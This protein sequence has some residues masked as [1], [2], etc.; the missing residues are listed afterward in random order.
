[1][2]RRQEALW[3]IAFCFLMMNCGTGVYEIWG[4]PFEW[5]HA[6]NT[7]EAFDS[8]VPV[9]VDNSADIESDFIVNEEH[10]KATCIRELIY[11]AREANKWTVSIVDDPRIEFGDI[12]EFT[13]G[14]KLYVEDFSRHLERGSEAILEVKGFLIPP[15]KIVG[16]GRIAGA[17]PPPSGTAPI[18]GGGGSGGGGETGGGGGGGETP[19]EPP[20]TCHPPNEF[21]TVQRIN[22]ENPGLL[23]TNTT[24]SCGQFTELVVNALHAVDPKWGHVGKTAGQTNYNLHAVDAIMHQDCLSRV[25]DIIGGAE[26][27]PKPGNPAWI[28]ATS[29]GQPWKA[30]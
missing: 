24:A 6:R 2:G 20:E 30:P 13:D 8:S 25:V 17:P 26:G 14:S 11:Q 23:A 15:A 12:L 3:Q 10:A 19:V 18:G 7:S 21:A 16:E 1:V 9:W 27:H 4:T 28:E 29:G 22:S 5:V